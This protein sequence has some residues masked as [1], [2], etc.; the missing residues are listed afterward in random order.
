MEPAWMAGFLLD[1]VR[2]ACLHHLVINH[3]KRSG[4]TESPSRRLVFCQC[5]E[6]HAW[7]RH[8]EPI[9]SVDRE[10]FY[11][12]N[13]APTPTLLSPLANEPLS[14]TFA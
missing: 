4:A 11:Q 13:P 6:T 9:N 5:F 1:D 14:E 7:N 12:L 3:A 2:V 8:P 10:G